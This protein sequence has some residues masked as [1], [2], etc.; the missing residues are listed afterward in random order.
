VTIDADRPFA[1]YADG[2]PI[3]QLPLRVRSVP[4]AIDVLVP[5]DGVSEGFAGLATVASEAR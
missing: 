5:A 2:D 3:G 4:G 1:M